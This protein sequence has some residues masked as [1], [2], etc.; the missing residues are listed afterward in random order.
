MNVEPMFKGEFQFRRYSDTSTQG[1]QVVFAVADREALEA[2]I[3]KEGK[4]FAAV[5]VEI[6]DDE[7]PVQQPEKPNVGPLCRE[8]V[9]LCKLSEFQEWVEERSPVFGIVFAKDEILRICNVNS[10]KDLDT[11]SVAADLFVKKIRLP[12][13]RYMASRGRATA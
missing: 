11:N 6:G 3:G 5:L 13:M 4:R 1:Q 8:A 9:E 2:F 10:R 12:F 7:L